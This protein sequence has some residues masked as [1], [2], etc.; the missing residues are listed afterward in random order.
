MR[1]IKV[2]GREMSADDWF[3][4]CLLWACTGLLA[5]GLAVVIAISLG[6]AT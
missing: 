6:G 3:L 4:W 5:G 2:W 1:F